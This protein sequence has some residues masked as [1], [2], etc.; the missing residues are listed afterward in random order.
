MEVV[1]VAPVPAVAVGVAQVVAKDP[2]LADQ[3]L[4]PLGVLRSR[5]GVGGRLVGDPGE[6]VLGL[7]EPLVVELLGGVAHLVGD[8]L[9]LVLG[10]S[11]DADEHQRRDADELEGY[12]GAR[13][14]LLF[15]GSR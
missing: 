11:A 5:T 1:A 8:A 14:H 3:Q 6:G 12:L 10:G 13:A 9:R 4:E 2:H 15:E 7:G